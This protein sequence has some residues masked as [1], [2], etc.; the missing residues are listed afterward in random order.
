MTPNFFCSGDDLRSLADSIEE[1]MINL[2]LWF[3]IN[4]LSLNVQNSWYLLS[5][6]KTNI[7]LSINIINIEKVSEVTF[8]GVI[9][10]DKFTWK[11][12]ILHMKN[13]VSKSLF[14]LNKS[15]YVL[16][17]NTLRTLYCSIILPY[18]NYCAE[19]WGNTYKTSLMPLV[20]LQKRAI[21]MINKA[22]FRDHTNPLFIRSG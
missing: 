5:K 6:I 7:S 4:K 9:L 20:L 21:R 12:H 18:F 8:L 17:C 1:E 11:S 15:K 22:G 3:D 13:K 2:K 14:I 10:D 19:I 16:Q